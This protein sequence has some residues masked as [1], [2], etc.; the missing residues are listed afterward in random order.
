MT[1][2]T[3]QRMMA[4]AFS[5]SDVGDVEHSECKGVV[6]VAPWT[7]RCEIFISAH[8]GMSE[9]LSLAS[10]TEELRIDESS[11]SRRSYVVKVFVYSTLPP[12]DLSERFKQNAPKH[13]EGSGQYAMYFLWDKAQIFKGMQN[14][15]TTQLSK[16]PAEKA[17]LLE[18]IRILLA[19]VSSHSVGKQS[20]RCSVAALH[21]VGN[22]LPSLLV[23]RKRKRWDG[24]IEKISTWKQAVRSKVEE[25]VPA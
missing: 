1:S 24:I 17:L 14:F 5:S 23:S 21:R 16:L 15:C 3:V 4:A 9:L 19:F 11:T 6:L 8:A 22:I 13:I 7:T 20:K 10:K 18:E 25:D 2:Q 12:P